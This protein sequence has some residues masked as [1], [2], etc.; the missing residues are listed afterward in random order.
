[1]ASAFSVVAYVA[2][3]IP[4]IG[5][6]ALA[7]LTSLRLAGLVFTGVIAALAAIVLGLLARRR[8]TREGG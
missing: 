7:E 1:M 8:V 3:S 6:G 5:E 2:I 4:V